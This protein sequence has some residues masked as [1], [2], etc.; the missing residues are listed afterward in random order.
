MLQFAVCLLQLFLGAAPCTKPVFCAGMSFFFAGCM[1]LFTHR[2][3]AFAAY[4]MKPSSHRAWTPGWRDGSWIHKKLPL[5]CWSRSR[6]KHRRTIPFVLFGVGGLEKEAEAE[7]EQGEMANKMNKWQGS[8][9]PGTLNSSHFTGTLFVS[10]CFRCA[11]LWLV[12]KDATC[13]LSSARRWLQFW[14]QVHGSLCMFSFW[15]GIG[16]A[17]LG[18]SNFLFLCQSFVCLA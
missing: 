9:I 16:R 14:H 13:G 1:H 8:C 4:Y 10:G 6:A 12:A 7:G 2:L 17:G 3:D 15:A 11:L 5:R 18:S